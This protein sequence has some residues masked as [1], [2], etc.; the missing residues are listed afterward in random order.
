MLRHQIDRTAQEL[1]YALQEL[2]RAEENVN[3]HRDAVASLR[4]Q[5]EAWKYIALDTVAESYLADMGL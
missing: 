2:G 1:D 3:Y 5:L 4:R